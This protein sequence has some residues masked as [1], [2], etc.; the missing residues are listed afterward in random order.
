VV[1]RAAEYPWAVYR[2]HED[3]TG[4]PARACTGHSQ[5]TIEA[6]GQ[7]L[8]TAFSLLRVTHPWS[9]DDY[10]IGVEAVANVR[11]VRRPVLEGYVQAQRAAVEGLRAH[12]TN[13]YLSVRLPTLPS[14]PLDPVDHERLRD[15]E[16]RLFTHILERLQVSRASHR[17]L[18]WLVR[19]AFRRGLPDPLVTEPRSPARPDASRID[20]DLRFHRPA[21]PTATLPIQVDDSSLRIESEL[22]ESHQSFLSVQTLLAHDYVR[23]PCCGGFFGVIQSLEFPVDAVISTHRPGDARPVTPAT[24]DDLAL[25]RVCRFTDNGRPRLQASV[26]LCVSAA[27]PAELERRVVRLRLAFSGI[28]LSRPP[29]GQLALFEEHLPAGT[30]A[31]AGSVPIAQLG[32]LRA[33]NPPA[34]GS[35]AGLY[36]GHTISG[37]PRAVLFDP[38]QVS[39]TGAPT[40]TLLTGAPGSGKTVCMELLMYHA[41]VLGSVIYDIDPKGDH[42]L[43]RLPDVADH[44]DVLELSAAKRFVGLL[45]PLRIGPEDTRE[46]LALDFLVG[47]LP[48]GAPLEWEI[49]IARA[50]RNVVARG[51]YACGEVADELQRRGGHARAAANAIWQHTA[52]GLARLGFARDSRAA[53][54]VGSKQITILRVR[55]LRAAMPSDRRAETAPE[56]RVGHLIMRLLAAYALKLADARQEH[57]C[58]VGIDQATALLADKAGR[59]LVDRIAHRSR[60][61]DFTPV[62]TTGPATDATWL[63]DRF[64]PMFCFR[65][66]NEQQARAVS[67]LLLA[68][69]GADAHVRG[70]ESAGPGRCVM[71]DHLGRVS[72]VQI[73]FADDR[74][75]PILDTRAAGHADTADATCLGER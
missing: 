45:D 66:Q 19:R 46:E 59:Q 67:R 69:R 58:I 36:I 32:G 43:E 35:R 37:T 48:D 38:V 15:T 12:T 18:S 52:S 21:T 31:T 16:A 56:E 24:L 57:H 20:T 75:L 33:A 9:V 26:S 3:D 17:Q 70:L 28:R 41:F 42:A 5:P 68:G 44:V 6:L 10:E 54:E 71:R 11:H 22:G 4:R 51:G 60:S 23:R 13:V 1:G 65:P 50:L 29:R 2:V 14:P 27:S 47:V 34:A 62:V 72:P 61:R 40:A 8:D 30:P 64:G 73:D 63:H 55:N 7:H 49:E 53:A 25:D 74:L 39:R